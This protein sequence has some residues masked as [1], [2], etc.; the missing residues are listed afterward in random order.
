MTPPTTSADS[1]PDPHSPL[2]EA[3]ARLAE[4]RKQLEY[5][6]AAI[7]E[8]IWDWDI[9]TDQ[10][11]RNARGCELLGLD[12]TFTGHTAA[13][14][15]E[16]IAEEDRLGM[17][18]ALQHCLS[19]HGPYHCEYR[20]RHPSGRLVW[21]RDR[22]NVVEYT[23]DGRPLRMIG[24]LSDISL[25]READENLRLTSS[26]FRH[27]HESI[28]ITDTAA[29]ILDV[30]D[31]FCRITG[32]LRSEI[33]GR[34]TR[35]LRSGLQT[36][37]FYADMW[38]G[39]IRDGVWQGELWNRK[40][41]GELFAQLGNISAVRNEAGQT[42][43]YV[44]LFSDITEIKESQRHL[45]HL[46]YHDALT[47]LPNRSLLAD[48]MQ[49]ALAQ[50]ERNA[51]L[52]AV[53][54]LDLD[55]FKP[56]NDSHG[57]DVGDL[58]LVEIARR[59]QASSRAGDT[60]ARMG[61]DEFALIYN[62]L[63][64]SEEC[65]Q[66]F[67]RLLAGI[68]EPVTLRGRELQVSASIG[69]TLFPLDGADP[70]TLLRHA[71]QAMYMAKQAGGNCFH[72]FDPERDR[73]LRAHRAAVAR[74][75][76]ALN[77]R[78]LELHYQPKVDI[79][80]N[81]IIGVEALLRWRHPQHGVILPGEFLPAVMDSDF[82]I[83]LGNW[84][85]A[86]AVDEIQAFADAG[87]P[88]PVSVNVSPNHL[89]HPDFIAHLQALL[90]RYPRLPSGMLELEILESTS[91]SDIGAVSR[92]MEACQQLGV[93]FALDDFGT[94]YGSLTYLRRLPVQTIKID[95]SFV[96]DMLEDNDDLAIVQGVIGLAAAFRREVIAEGVE[97][98]AHRQA[99]LALGCHLI[100]GFGVAR[101]MPPDQLLVWIREGEAGQ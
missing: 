52:A 68:A 14:F 66:V 65:E 34:N 78:E 86:T 57:H 64:H 73:S 5:V 42:T 62:G 43:H 1:T 59:L 69:I 28:V 8:G 51:T 56:V 53:A 37:E 101:P 67:A 31:A 81:R 26:V 20:V 96:R 15:R 36:S 61:G 94:G 72:L 82:E 84:I 21:V 63:E 13:E 19:G 23:A 58:L 12:H 47:Q 49:M 45:E 92:I 55:G 24:S 6:F 98:A 74:V 9:S 16:L 27:A 35:F 7:G 77:D 39:L 90:A 89:A 10:V 4:S 70:D 25:E 46:A 30:N 100:Q 2:E 71:D 22:G 41:N 79:R 54:Y 97:T 91:F 18:D 32:Y 80:R 17:A 33:I 88:L 87:H 76:S 99:L 83:E 50:A 85:L 29:N 44:G 11:S 93:R 75:E 60:V 40:K 3:L 95:Q 48:R 38:R